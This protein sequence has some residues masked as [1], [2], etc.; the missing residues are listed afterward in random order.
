MEQS[1]CIREFMKKKFTIVYQFATAS[2]TGPSSG[3][4][5]GSQPKRGGGGVQTNI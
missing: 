2:S 1:L 5:T 3:F 4:G